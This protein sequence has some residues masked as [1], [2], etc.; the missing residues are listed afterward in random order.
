MKRIH[1]S[2]PMWILERISHE[3][4]RLRIPRQAL[5]KLWLAERLEEAED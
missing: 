1:L 5:I 3:A 4:R 2:F